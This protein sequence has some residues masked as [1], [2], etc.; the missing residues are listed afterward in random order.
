M[1]TGVTTKRELPA[2]F[3]RLSRGFAVIFVGESSAATAADMTTTAAA[4]AATSRTVAFGPGFVDLKIAAAKFLAVEVRNGFGGFGVIGHFYKGE[5]ASSAGFA[6]RDNMNAPNLAEGLKQ[7]GQIGF[8]SL[9]AHISD[10]KIFHTISPF[11]LL[12]CGRNLF[13]DAASPRI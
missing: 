4:A 11:V 1:Q 8:G 12:C 5:T 9:K 10:K 3:A 6:I 2:G 13:M 7:R